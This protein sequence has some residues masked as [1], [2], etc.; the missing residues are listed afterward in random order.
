MDA[1][2][3][4]FGVVLAPVAAGIE[5]T[6]LALVEAVVRRAGDNI[7]TGLC[8]RVGNLHGRAEAR[9]VGIERGVT[10]QN[11]LLIDAGEVIALHHGRN[12]GIE[13]REVIPAFRQ[14]C[15]PVDG[16][17]N[18]IVAER[19]KR[20]AHRLGFRFCRER[21]RLFRCG[22]RRC[23]FRCSRIGFLYGGRF[24]RRFL[25]ACRFILRFLRADCFCRAQHPACPER[26]RAK[27][28]QDQDQPQKPRCAGFLFS[29]ESSCHEKA[30]FRQSAKLAQTKRSKSSC[31]NARS[32][33]AKPS[34]SA[35]CR[36]MPDCVRTSGLMCRFFARTRTA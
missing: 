10:D 34:S 30:P 35:V 21:L 32:C 4:N 27:Q 14:L 12:R 18:Q 16:V 31:K 17:V 29:G 2:R 20:H 23:D 5:N 7:K 19:H 6:G 1:E 28:Q 9:V 24:L 36:F 25:R 22:I 13:G 3:G 8:Q 11:G 15:R 33:A 26:N